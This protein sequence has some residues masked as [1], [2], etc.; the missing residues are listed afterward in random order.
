MAQLNHNQEAQTYN[1]PQYGR[2]K[3]VLFIVML[4]PECS[5]TA[6]TQQLPGQMLAANHGHTSIVHLTSLQQRSSEACGLSRG[7]HLSGA[8][9]AAN[10]W[11]V[12]G[13]PATSQLHSCAFQLGTLQP[14][15]SHYVRRVG[16]PRKEW[17]PTVMAEAAG[18]AGWQNLQT[19][20]QDPLR[21]RAAMSSR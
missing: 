19:L 16:R 8:V 10:T 12:L 11:E 15:T 4:L 6:P 3:A 5:A 17:I 1:L 13:A 2:D 20:A 21:W 7:H 14:A 18:K 9:S